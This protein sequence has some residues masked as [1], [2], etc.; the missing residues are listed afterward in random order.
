MPIDRKETRAVL[1]LCSDALQVW[2]LMQTTAIDKIGSQTRAKQVR[3][4]YLGQWY[5]RSLEDENEDTL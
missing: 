3:A 1:R 2:D 4:E 5:E